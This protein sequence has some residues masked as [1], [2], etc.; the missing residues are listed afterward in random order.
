MQVYLHV[1]H[2]LQNNRPRNTSKSQRSSAEGLKYTRQ[3]DL[4]C[5]LKRQSCSKAEGRQKCHDK[6]NLKPPDPAY[7]LMFEHNH[8]VLQLTLNLG[9]Q[10]P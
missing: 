1:G 10:G 5:N 4:P 2:W 7:I 9:S 8:S 3:Q 6:H